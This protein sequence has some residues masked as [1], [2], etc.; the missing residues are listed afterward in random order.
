M[1][2]EGYRVL[3]LWDV[4]LFPSVL[5]QLKA[6]AQVDIH[7]PDR[8]L[9]AA[10]IGNYDAI[11]VALSVP[12][13]R[14]LIALATRMKT[15][16]T[17]STGL[18]HL[19]LAALS[20]RGIAVQSIKVEYDLLDQV[21]A[22]AELAW[23][24]LL[25]ASRKLPAAHNA[26]LE[27]RWA[28]DEFRGTQIR[29]KTV[30]IVGVGRLGAMMA[31]YAQAFGLQVL[32]CDPAPRL[33]LDFVDYVDLDTLLARAD[34]ISLHVHLNESTRHLLDR[35]AFSRMKEGVTLINTSRGGLID[36]AALVEALES[37]KVGAAGLDVIDGE[38]RT[39]LDQHPLIKLAQQHP[40]VV[41]SPHIGGV[42]LESQS[43]TL[44]FSADR[45]ARSLA[46]G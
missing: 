42:T 32:G 18:D 6:V 23:A 26:A 7:P 3:C 37:G 41:I 2:T 46:A 21:S 45:L 36:E 14:E 35:A 38:W 22:T 20:E 1:N 44:K 43:I 27:G 39:D 17:P 9:V 29:G 40:G 33:T 12:L 31:R 28:R 19:D 25:A 4:T 30:G 13:D 11:L 16:V 5:D 34:I 15:V 24:L 8:E 10:I